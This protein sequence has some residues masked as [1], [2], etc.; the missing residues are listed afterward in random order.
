[1]PKAFKYNVLEIERLKK[2][3]NPKPQD[4]TQKT[5]QHWKLTN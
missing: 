3:Y 4:K 1:M 5:K 2:K